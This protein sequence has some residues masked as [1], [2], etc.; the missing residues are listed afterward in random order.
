MEEFEELEEPQPA[1]DAGLK[2]LILEIAKTVILAAIIFGLVSWLTVRVRVEKISMM[3]TL[4]EGELALVYKMAYEWG[5]PMRGDVVIFPH[6]TGTV[7]ED[8]VKRVI[9][10]PGDNVEIKAGELYI[11]GSLVKEPYIKE[12][13]RYE[14]TWHVP[15]DNLF[16]LGDNRNHSLDSHD[17]GYVPLDI[18]VGRAVLVYWPLT[19]A[20]MLPHRDITAPA[21]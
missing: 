7:T 17:W 10:L 3:P 12:P 5:K 16:V 11:N 8:Y 19:E 14:G 13:M 4:Q 15:P 20:K 9:G 21:Q 18:V 2:D 6:Q 1:P